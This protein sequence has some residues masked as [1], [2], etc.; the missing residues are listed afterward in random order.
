M[1]TNKNEKRE[2][3]VKDEAA[4]RRE[5]KMLMGQL[6]DLGFPEETLTSVRAALEDFATEGYGVTRTF[7]FREF[8]VSVLLQLSTQP[9]V[10][11]FARV[12]KM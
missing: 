4:R 8:G 1:A 11:S 2:K 7:P 3:R 12:R 9:H 5:A 6:E 10:T